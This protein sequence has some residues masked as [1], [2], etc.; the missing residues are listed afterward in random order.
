MPFV[1]TVVWDS[2]G[3]LYAGGSF[4]NTR[5]PY[6]GA[7]VDLRRRSGKRPRKRS[8]IDPIRAIMRFTCAFGA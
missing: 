3:N 1:D 6:E 5:P 2:A 7:V 8:R 4:Q